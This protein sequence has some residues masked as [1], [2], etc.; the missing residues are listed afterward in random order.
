MESAEIYTIFEK[1]VRLKGNINALPSSNTCKGQ[2]NSKQ[3][4]SAPGVRGAFFCYNYTY[5]ILSV[6]G[7]LP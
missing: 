3:R 6:W 5:A 2:I 7:H 4:K 1:E